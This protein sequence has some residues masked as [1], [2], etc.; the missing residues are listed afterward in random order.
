MSGCTE[1][2]GTADVRRCRGTAVRVGAGVA[3]GSLSLT[4]GLSGAAGF[5]ILAAA[6][7]VMPPNVKNVTRLARIF[8]ARAE[9]ARR[10]TGGGVVITRQLRYPPLPVPQG[11]TF[12]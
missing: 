10:R 9:R 8:S 3:V 4:G 12:G 6:K 5:W 7:A 1:V 2:I 11:G